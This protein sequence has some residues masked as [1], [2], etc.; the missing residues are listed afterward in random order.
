[1]I[2]GNHNQDKYL[3][4]L[5]NL[6]INK[7]SDLSPTT[8]ERPQIQ[9]EKVMELQKTRSTP[10][11]EMMQAFGKDREE[12][13]IDNYWTKATYTI[14]KILYTQLCE[15]FR[16]YEEMIATETESDHTK[17]E[18][19]KDVLTTLSKLGDFERT[20]LLEA[21]RW[22]SSTKGKES[23]GKLKAY[24]K[25]GKRGLFQG[26]DQKTDML[27]RGLPCGLDLEVTR[28]NEPAGP[29]DYDWWK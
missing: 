21:Q 3:E 19:S 10:T 2:D 27:P 8:W 29:N 7:I 12:I 28:D 16:N 22:G 6:Y 24:F 17:G 25:E 13:V 4:A 23:Y 26:E 18:I 14:R 11:S 9:G 15:Y 20:I 5:K 1:M